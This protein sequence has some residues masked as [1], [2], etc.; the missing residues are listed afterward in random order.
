[1]GSR[2]LRRKCYKRETKVAASNV[3]IMLYFNA[4]KDEL[5]VLELQSEKHEW[6]T[7]YPD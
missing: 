6:A 4:R 5:G 2:K 7:G 1:M 3:G